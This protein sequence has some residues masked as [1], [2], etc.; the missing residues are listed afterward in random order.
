M[1]EEYGIRAGKIT[2]QEPE[3]EIEESTT[4][5]RYVMCLTQEEMK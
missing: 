3:C 4:D 1:R 2:A 5:Q